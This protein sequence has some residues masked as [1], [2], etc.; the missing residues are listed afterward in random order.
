MDESMSIKIRDQTKKTSTVTTVDE[1]VN[2]P[3]KSVG[4]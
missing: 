3:L 1:K 2:Y 4:L